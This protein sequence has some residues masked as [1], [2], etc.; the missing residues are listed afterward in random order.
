M[1]DFSIET[2]VRQGELLSM[3]YEHFNFDRRTL[4]IPITKNGESRVIP[5]SNKAIKIIKDV[6]RRLDGKIF[7]M[8]RYQIKHWWRQA[9]RRAKINGLRWHDLRR[10]ACSLLFEKGLNVP[11]VQLI[12]GHK[13][14]T[15]LLNT[16]TKL[17]PEKIALKL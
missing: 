12:S 15:I 17:K 7:P 1:V 3:K 5:L 4:L 10:H 2:A 8:K 16:Y 11:E 14:P 13:D 9:L 6:P